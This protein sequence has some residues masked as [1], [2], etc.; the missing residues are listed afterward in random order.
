MHRNQIVAYCALALIWGSS[1][2]LVLRVVEAFGW[3]G[4]VSLR[5]FAASALLL[6]IA[7]ASRRTL[8]FGG[9]C[10]PLAVIGATTV[11][12][13]LIALSFATPRIGTA[14]AAILVA[15][16][17]LFSMLI[18]RVLGTERLAP[19]SRLGL[20]LSFGGIVLLVGFPAAP[21]T[22]DFVLG[23]ASSLFGAF[24]AAFGSNYLRRSLRSV[25]PWEQTIGAFF[26]GGA[27]S[28]P[29][30]L[31]VPIPAPPRVEDVLYLLLL[32]GLCSSLAYVLYFRLVAELGATIAISVE[33]VVTLVAVSIGALFLGEALSPVQLAGGAI[34]LL[35]CALLVGLLPR[36]L[37]RA[38]A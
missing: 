1:F 34:I 2:V 35:G 25:G 18:G 14:M 24:C 31:F 12:G 37:R 8:H 6:V 23:C 21:V 26:F 7:R 9:R 5:A 32:A 15:T 38:A 19:W 16:I 13:Q 33:F 17:P 22:A 10:F 11:A 3:I 36:R 4:A 27:L 20:A 28:L 30:L 29:L